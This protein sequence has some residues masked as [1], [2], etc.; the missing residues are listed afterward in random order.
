MKR[1]IGRLT[2]CVLILIMFGWKV[3]DEW[4]YAAV[5]KRHADLKTL[6]AFIENG[7]EHDKLYTFSQNGETYLF[8]AKPLTSRSRGIMC[9]PSGPACYIFD[10]S[11]DMVD[12]SLDIGDNPRFQDKWPWPPEER[13][14]ERYL[15]S[16]HQ[17]LSEQ[18]K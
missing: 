15:I 3:H 10:S 11:G 13:N 1:Y 4:K 17:F 6:S 9:I 16:P 14:F 12:Y 8:W 5:N 7:V 18:K 2:A